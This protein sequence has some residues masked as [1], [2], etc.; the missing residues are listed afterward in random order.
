MLLRVLIDCLDGLSLQ[1]WWKG[2]GQ[3][4]GLL[5]ISY[6]QSVKVSGAS[7]LELCLRI[8]LA[9]FDKLR[10]RSTCFLQKVTDVCNLLWHGA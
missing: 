10:V 3:L 1:A 6:H 7:D 9:D 5:C 4:I 8:T 2:L